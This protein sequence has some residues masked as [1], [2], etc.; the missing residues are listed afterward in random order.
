MESLYVVNLTSTILHLTRRILYMS[1]LKDEVVD[2]PSLTRGTQRDTWIGE[3]ALLENMNVSGL[4]LRID[5]R[6]PLKDGLGS[7]ATT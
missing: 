2:Q 3:S 4:V 7:N 5:S 1:F 6:V